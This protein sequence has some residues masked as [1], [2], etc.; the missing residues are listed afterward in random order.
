MPEMGVPSTLIAAGLTTSQAPTINARSVAENSAVDFRQV[1]Q[2][3]GVRVGLG[4][5]HVHVT[6]HAAGDRDEWRT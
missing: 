3:V 4:Q 1:E 2:Q 6:R 5:Q